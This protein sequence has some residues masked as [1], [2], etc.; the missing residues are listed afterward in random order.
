MDIEKLNLADLILIDSYKAKCP[1]CRN[2]TTHGMFVDSESNKYE[3]C[4]SCRAYTVIDS[5]VD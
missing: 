4:Q 3:V 5:D 2:T 1:D